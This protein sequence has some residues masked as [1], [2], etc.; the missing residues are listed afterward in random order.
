MDTYQDNVLKTLRR[1][2]GLQYGIRDRVQRPSL[3]ADS[4]SRIA[5]NTYMPTGIPLKPE[6]RKFFG[7]P[8]VRGGM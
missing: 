1:A 5:G 8:T 4:G 6:H 7:I 2:A 3:G